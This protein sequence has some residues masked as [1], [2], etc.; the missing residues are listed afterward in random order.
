MR[1]QGFE[2]TDRTVVLG[3]VAAYSAAAVVLLGWLLHVW[4]TVAQAL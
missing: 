1:I 3:L 4:P 2:L